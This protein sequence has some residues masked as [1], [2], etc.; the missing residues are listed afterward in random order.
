MPRIPAGHRI[1]GIPDCVY[2]IL[3]GSTESKDH[4]TK[5]PIYARYG[6]AYA[7]LLDPRTKTVEGRLP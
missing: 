4:E 1:E 2:E 6:V 7:W 5:M 3:S